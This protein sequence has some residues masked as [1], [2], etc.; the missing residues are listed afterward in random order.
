MRSCVGDGSGDG[1][2]G[3]GGEKSRRTNWLRA[4]IGGWGRGRRGRLQLETTFDD[5]YRR[6][7]RQSRGLSKLWMLSALSPRIVRV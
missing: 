2:G 6:E 5:G 7:I 4:P 3:E 1:A